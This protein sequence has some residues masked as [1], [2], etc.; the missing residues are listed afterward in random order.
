MRVD[1]VLANRITHRKAQQ[2]ARLADT[3]VADQEQLEEIVTVP[4]T[5]AELTVNTQ[6]R[7]KLCEA[8][9]CIHIQNRHI[10]M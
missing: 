8:D 5:Q 2:E 10:C 4:T 1:E 9:I 6:S 3:R 7:V